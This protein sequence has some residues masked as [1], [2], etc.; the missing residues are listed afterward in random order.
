[1]LIKKFQAAS[2]QEALQLAKDELGKDVII[3]HIKSVKPKGIY[4]LFKKPL[5]EITA[6]VDE[7]KVYDR[8]SHAQFADEFKSNPFEVKV[9]PEEEQH[10]YAIEQKLD[11]LQSMLEK[12]LKEQALVMEKEREKEEPAEIE[13]TAAMACVQMIYNQLV[14]NEVEEVFANKVIAEIEQSLNPD[15]TVDNILSSIYQKL[16]LK[17]GETKELELTDGKTKYVFFIGP[18]GVGKTTTIAKLA[19]TLKLRRKAKVALFTADT[20][21][22]AAV[23]QLRSYATIL[24]IP[25][26]VIYSEAEMQEALEEF[27]DYDVVLID[28]AGRSHRN[29]EQRD[30]LEKLLLTVPEE[31]REIYLVLSATTKYRDLVKITE[32]YAEIT[33]YSLIFTKLDETGGVGN[34]FNIKMLT[35]APLSYTTFGQNVPDDIMKINPQ[36]IAKQLLGGGES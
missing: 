29:Q 19:S 30:D 13:Q 27:K 26:R 6:A 4:K 35:G 22:I 21:R 14:A 32:A 31:R 8:K 25:L 34:V 12:Q 11:S 23:D 9:R 17:L 1:M 5:V 20:Y 3:T 7:E 10:S 18:T 2:E 28:T 33:D 24:N 15:A 16:V 36:S